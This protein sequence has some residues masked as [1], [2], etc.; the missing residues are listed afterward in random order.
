MIS[1]LTAINT[2]AKIVTI[3]EL[4]ELLKS[5]EVSTNNLVS[6]A[7]QCGY[8][9]NHKEKTADYFLAFSTDVVN[10]VKIE[11]MPFVKCKV[12][13]FNGCNWS[14]VETACHLSHKLELLND[15]YQ[16]MILRS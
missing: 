9:F 1:L 16:V 2:T 8:N 3:T 11:P 12:K 7:P 6:L 14:L 5:K 10:V 15:E 13:A 4:R